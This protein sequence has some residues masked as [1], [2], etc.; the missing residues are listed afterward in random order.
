MRGGECV[1]VQARWCM[2]GGANFNAAR[3]GRR[4]E[5]QRGAERR[6]EGQR[7]ASRGP[8]GDGMAVLKE[9]RRGFEPRAR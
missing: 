7:G 8:S 9:R 2:R 1:V 6:R 4:R 5:A 3:C